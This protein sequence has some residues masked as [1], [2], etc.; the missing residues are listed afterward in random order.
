MR[1]YALCAL[2][3]VTVLAGP[4]CDGLVDPSDNI[5]EEI[6]GV[7]VPGTANQHEVPITRNGEYS[8]RVKS[9]DPSD[10]VFVHV[11]LGIIDQGLCATLQQRFFVG[12][13]QFALA[14]S[15]FEATYCIQVIDPGGDIITESVAYVLEFSHP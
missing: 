1:H 3:S 2:L 9:L 11:F 7:L 8:L 4:A 6:P 14:G 15:I 5:V 10:G 13:D 12:H